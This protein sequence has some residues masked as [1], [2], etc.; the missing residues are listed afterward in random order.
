MKLA[1]V[2]VLVFI[3]SSCG[4]GEGSGGLYIGGSG[5]LVFSFEDG[6]PPSVVQDADQ[7]PIDLLINVR[8]T[9]EYDIPSVEFTLT[10]INAY[11]FENFDPGPTPL[12]GPLRGKALVQNRIVDGEPSFVELGRTVY[13]RE[14]RSASLDFTLKAKACYPYATSATATICL[15]NDY[16]DPD[17]SCDPNSASISASAAPITI[18][19]IKT[20]PA[21]PDRLR[22]MFDIEKIGSQHIWAPYQ[23][24]SCPNDRQMIT[25]ESDRVYVR[26]DGSDRITCTGLN[27]ASYDATHILSAPQEYR[28]PLSEVRADA[29]G[30]VRLSQGRAPVQC[31][32]TSPSGTDGKGTIDIVAAYYVEDSISKTFSVQRSGMSGR[33]P[34]PSTGSGRTDG[35]ADAPSTPQTGS[36]TGDPLE[37]NGPDP[38]G[39]EAMETVIRVRTIDHSGE[40]FRPVAGTT[41]SYS[42]N[43]LGMAG[44]KP[45]RLASGN[46]APQ[47][48]GYQ[49]ITKRISDPMTLDLVFTTGRTMSFD[50][51]EF[52]TLRIHGLQESQR[53]RLEPG[54]TQEVEFRLTR[55]LTN[56]VTINAFDPEGNSIRAKALLIVDTENYALAP[57]YVELVTPGSFANVATGAYKIQ[58]SS[59]EYGAK[60]YTWSPT[61]DGSE[62][63]DVMFD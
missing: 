4:S 12:T 17:A 42:L 10:G 40:T 33:D 55:S 21:G 14:L 60:Q 32:F 39:S 30:Y 57:P 50:D 45:Y 29:E 27:S 19:N 5:G 9:G 37:N 54:T 62:R 43:A 28:T 53:I 58:V 16:Y 8:N 3:L 36:D 35:T 1:I 56:K 11:D 22:I 7:T 13:T 51:I 61:H 24:Q 23:G 26:V 49:T 44:F 52:G 41:A 63:I 15:A 18:S 20:S 25:Q 31:V 59:D 34:A 6:T 48:D 38:T 2:L 46:Y 47:A